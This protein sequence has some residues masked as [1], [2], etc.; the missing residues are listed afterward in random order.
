VRLDG[1]GRLRLYSRVLPAVLTSLAEVA[2]LAD[3][4]ASGASGGNLVGVQIPPS[5]P[6]DFSFEIADLH[7]LVEDVPE[8]LPTTGVANRIYATADVALRIATNHS[9]AMEEARTESVAVGFP[10]ET[11]EEFADHSGFIETVE[12]DTW[13]VHVF[14][15]RGNRRVRPRG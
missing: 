13:G 6:S 8:S 7:R 11:G 2:E 12:S 10:G 9:E 3:A 15:R 4:L 5:A 1:A 14:A